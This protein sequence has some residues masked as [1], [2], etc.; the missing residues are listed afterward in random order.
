MRL[1]IASSGGDRIARIGED[2]ARQQLETLRRKTNASRYDELRR[3]LGLLQVASSEDL[4]AQQQSCLQLHG[5]AIQRSDEVQN[6]L[7][8]SGVDFKQGRTEH[9]ALSAEITS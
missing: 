5:V 1:S 4:L 7:T 6:E 8:E 9:D 3:Q 2:I